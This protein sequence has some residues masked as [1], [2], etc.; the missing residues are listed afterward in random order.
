M[1]W[2]LRLDVL[3]IVLAPM[4]SPIIGELGYGFLICYVYFLC[5]MSAIIFGQIISEEGQMRDKWL[6]Y[7]GKLKKGED[8]EYKWTIGIV[9]KLFGRK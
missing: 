9:K 7:Y 1:N 5:I 4:V 3:L 2:N 8:E 6:E